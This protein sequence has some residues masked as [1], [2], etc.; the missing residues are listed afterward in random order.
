MPKLV[1]FRNDLRIN[2]NPALSAAIC[3]SSESVIGLFLICP[4][5]WLKH[6]WGSPRVEF[7]M[8]NVQ[9]HSKQLNLLNI[10][11]LIAEVDTF[12]CAP[13]VIARIVSEHNCSHVYAGREFGV[14]E[15]DRDKKVKTSLLKS[16]IQ[17]DVVDD[18][19]IIPVEKVTTQQG[20]GYLVFSPFRK[21]WDSIF[22]SSFVGAPLP[23]P[24]QQKVDISSDHV[25]TEIAGFKNSGLMDYW[26]PGESEAIV[27]RD[28]FLESLVDNYHASRDYPI[29]DSTST[30]SP[31][32]AVGAISPL[33]C[34]LPLI[35]RMGSNPTTWSIGARTWQ[36]E[37]VW[38]DFYRQLMWNNPRVSKNKP[39]K[40]WTEN[41]PWKNDINGF[42]NWRNG[43]T[44][45]PII[46]AAMKQLLNTGWMHN[47]LRMVTAMFLTK[48]LLIDWRLGERYFA[49][50]LVDYDFASNNGG[51]QWAASTGADSVPYFRI[52]NPLLQAKRFD[53]ENKFSDK[54][55]L[56][57]K[58]MNPIV[59]LSKSRL[60]AIAA[61][62]EAQLTA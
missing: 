46:D 51:W 17:F 44:G 45:V 25:P 28:H 60:R 52:F 59:D 22:P 2:D 35:E 10:P 54:W 13:D 24:A 18:Q 21:K 56:G 40:Q 3:A 42:N 19:T 34:L 49:E 36:S 53:A 31:W 15:I 47:R 37:L 26:L 50:K 48:N 20:N 4:K 23:I 8:K 7:L 33:T 57:E 58:I 14:D 41:V 5:T 29:L 11:L 1:W 39:L 6:N 9:E 55:N 16:G 12:E 27:R 62:K 61:F 43:N 30:L 32:L 38:R